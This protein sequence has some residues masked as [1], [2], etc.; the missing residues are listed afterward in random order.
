MTALQ[1]LQAR[2]IGDN[3]GIRRERAIDI[4]VDP[5]DSTD[6][7]VISSAATALSLDD[8]MGH[9][10]PHCPTR[11]ATTTTA[12]PAQPTTDTEKKLDTDAMADKMADKIA[13][14]MIS[15]MQP[16]LEKQG[17]LLAMFAAGRG[18]ATPA[19]RRVSFGGGEEAAEVETVDLGA[20]ASSSGGHAAVEDD[21]E[22]IA[23]AEA[24]AA[25]EAI[26]KA[27]ISGAAAGKPFKVPRA[28]AAKRART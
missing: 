14:K 12:N 8:T 4:D 17:E 25:I 28:N 1:V 22:A 21:E 3:K 19:R 13:G 20:A 10:A 26:E 7:D 9:I 18:Q 5:A 16:I 24:A 11:I 15:S 2:H 23:A 27:R 6:V